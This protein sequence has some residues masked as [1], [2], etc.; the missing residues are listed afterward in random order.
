MQVKINN[1]RIQA[2]SSYLPYKEIKCKNIKSVNA[3]E[4][5]NIIKVTG[6]ESFHVANEIETSSDMCYYAT[7]ELLNN[8]VIDKT[9]IDGLIFVSQTNDYILPSTSVILQNRIGLSKD[10]VCID[11]HYGCS[12]YIYGVLQAS[13]WISSGLCNNVLVLSGDTT[14]KMINEKDCSL[15]MVF[16]D[17]GTATLINRSDSEMCFS[18]H[19]DG[20]GYDKLIIPAGGFRLPCSDETKIQNM[21]EDG[22]IRSQENLYMDGM[23]YFLSL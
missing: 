2:I 17:A 1:I 21:D 4:I 23:E 6:V 5:E 10:T 16:G 7:M 15:K 22:N 13:L 9:K 14:S 20:S 12:G 11:I 8:N 18:I 19:S 3:E